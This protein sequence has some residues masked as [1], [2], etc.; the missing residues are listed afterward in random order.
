MCVCVC[1]CVCLRFFMDLFVLAI[2]ILLVLVWTENLQLL[3]LLKK[4]KNITQEDRYF[5]TAKYHNNGV[6][7]FVGSFFFAFQLYISTI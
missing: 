6:M 3:S 4:F 5:M 1:V 2:N 7:F